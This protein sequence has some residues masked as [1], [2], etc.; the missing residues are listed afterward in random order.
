MKRKEYFCDNCEEKI[1]RRGNESPCGREG[2]TILKGEPMTVTR[3]LD[4]TQAEI[5]GQ[6]CYQC[7][8]TLLA[9]RLPRRV[10]ARISWGPDD[11]EKIGPL[12]SDPPMP[13]IEL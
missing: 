2:F 11:V 5:F 3:K 4:Y 12:W 8:R 7:L 10:D 9:Y 1:E 13:P 6:L